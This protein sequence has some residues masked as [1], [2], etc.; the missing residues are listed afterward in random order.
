MI[1]SE[2]EQ[3]AD[4]YLKE[5]FGEGTEQISETAIKTIKRAYLHALSIAQVEIDKL[6]QKMAWYDEHLKDN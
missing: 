3:L 2:H 6:N 4:N 1:T 5:T